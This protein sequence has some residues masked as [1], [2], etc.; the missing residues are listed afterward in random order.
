MAKSVLDQIRAL[1]AQKAELMQGARAEALQKAKS[2]V[3]ALNSLGLNYRLVEARGQGSGR[4]GMRRIDSSRPCPICKFQTNPPHD[5]RA[6]RGQ[7]SKKPFGI[8]E[9]EERGMTKVG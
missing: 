9:L 6:H 4:K 5:A 8:R 3:S 2:A 7:K 1:E